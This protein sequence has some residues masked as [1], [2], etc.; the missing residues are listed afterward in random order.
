[1]PSVSSF[2]KDT[3]C[4]V[5]TSLRLNVIGKDLGYLFYYWSSDGKSFKQG[6]HDTTISLPTSLN[7]NFWV[8]VVTKDGDNNSRRDS[9]WIVLDSTFTDMRDGQPYHAVR[10]G[11][12]VW[13]AKNLNFTVDSSWWYNG[14]DYSDEGNTYNDSLS[15]GSKFGRLYKWTALMGIADSCKPN[16]CTIP[17]SHRGICPQGWHVPSDTD[18]TTL[19][20][21][22]Q[23]DSRVGSGNA[24]RA[25]KAKSAWTFDPDPSVS[26]LDL[27][28]FHALPGG[29]RYPSGDFDDAGNYGNWWTASIGNAKYSW[30]RFMASGYA[31]VDQYDG[32]GR[33]SARC[34]HD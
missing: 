23:K 32:N 7:G 27:F 6:R 4:Q 15:S 17:T 20:G 25:L 24:G 19:V 3:L 2:P 28:G 29:T 21:E 33:F 34:I 30:S 18:W 13:M 26:G 16:T 22:V 1:M 12:Q 11:S 14:P 10:I 8:Y 5:G 9:L 31:G